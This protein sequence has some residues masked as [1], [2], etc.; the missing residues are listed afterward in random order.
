MGNRDSKRDWGFAGDY[1]QAMWLMLQQEEADDYVI[2]TGET[3]SIHELLDVAF[4]EV[5]ITDWKPLVKQD[6]RFLRPAEVDLLIGDAAKAKER[7]GWEPTVGFTELVSM[8][9][10]HDIAE[11]KALAGL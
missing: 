11:Q 3:H 7:L 8:M 2:S 6:P 10:K 4:G 9:V 1:V 5:G